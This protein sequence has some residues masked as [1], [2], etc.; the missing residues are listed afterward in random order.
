[1]IRTEV[2]VAKNLRITGPRSRAFWNRLGNVATKRLEDRI[3]RKG[4]DGTGKRIPGL[5]AGSHFAA[6]D[7][8]R[9]DHRV[10]PTWIRLGGV[11]SE[12]SLSPN[13]AKAKQRAGARP[14]RDGRLTGRMWDN[15]TATLVKEGRDV[16]LRLS[17]AKTDRRSGTIGYTRKYKG[18]EIDALRGVKN[19]EKAAWIQ[20]AGRGLTGRRLFTLMAIPDSDLALYVEMLL[21]ELRLVQGG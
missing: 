6:R 12:V 14:V 8:A 7:D 2:R 1:M 9:F 3:T 4:R 21:K 16:Y 15:L 13:Y 11:L 19:S 10:A 17:F 20:F 18:Q 5:S